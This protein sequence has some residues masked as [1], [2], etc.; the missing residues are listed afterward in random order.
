RSQNRR[1]IMERYS[2]F[3]AARLVPGLSREAAAENSPGREPWVRGPTLCAK[4][5]RGDR[6]FRPSGAAPFGDGY[7]GLTPWAILCRRFAAESIR[8]AD[9]STDFRMNI[10]IT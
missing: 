10:Q 9:E 5:R 2:V 4:P 8:R 6:I 3:T 1:R 7:P